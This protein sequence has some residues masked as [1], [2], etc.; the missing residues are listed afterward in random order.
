ME[1]N[2]SSTCNCTTTFANR[3]LSAALRL[4]LTTLQKK[5]TLEF[6]STGIRKLWIIENSLEFILTRPDHIRHIFSSDINSMYTNLDQAFVIRAVTRE[7]ENAAHHMS[8]RCMKV[9]LHT[10]SYGNQRDL[11]I[12]SDCNNQQLRFK[13]GLYTLNQIHNLLHFVVKNVYF[14]VGSALFRQVQGI[15]MGGNASPFLANLALV[16]LE[17]TYVELNPNTTLQHSIF[18]YLDDFAVVNHPDFALDYI[19]RTIYPNFTGIQLIPNIPKR[20][21]EN[22]LTETQFL[23]LDIWVTLPCNTSPSTVFISLHDK[24]FAFGFHVIKFPHL[25]SDVYTPQS[26]TTYFTELVRLYRINT[27]SYWFMQNVLDLTAYCIRHNGFEP[28]N[29]LVQFVKFTGRI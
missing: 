26:R 13:Q 7:I 2:C 8:V 4:T 29:L 15:P 28:M 22:V 16:H 24:R 6:E 21:R 1:T 12:W 17:H 3:V 19:Y 20:P 25:D 9:R 23:D 14:T 18:R 11:A 10:T 27:H 5:F